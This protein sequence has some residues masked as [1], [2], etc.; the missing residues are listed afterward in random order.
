VQELLVMGAWRLCYL[1]FDVKRLTDDDA[2]VFANEYRALQ[3]S[4]KS[5][6]LIPILLCLA[7]FRYVSAP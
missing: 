3:G 1:I 6:L 5:K 7:V 2:E 4:K